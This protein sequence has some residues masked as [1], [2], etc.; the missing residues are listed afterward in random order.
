[1]TVKTG[2]SS[3]FIVVFKVFQ[4]TLENLIS[5]IDFLSLKAISKE[6]CLA[7]STD[8]FNH[9][10][11]FDSNITLRHSNNRLHPD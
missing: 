5:D 8:Q 11:I 6:N 7:K 4:N 10:K 1:M 9:L 3:K 2:T